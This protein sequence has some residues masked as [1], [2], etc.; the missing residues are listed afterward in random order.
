VGILGEPAFDP[1]TTA[2]EVAEAAGTSLEALREAAD[3]GEGIS[4]MCEGATAVVGQLH[5]AGQ[6]DA[7]LGLGGSGNT[8]IATAAMRSLPVGVPKVMVSTMASGDTEPY[9][10]ARDIAM[11]YSVADVEGLNQLS[12]QVIANAALATVGM[13]GA[14]VRVRRRN[15]ILLVS[16]LVGG[17]ILTP[18]VVSAVFQT[19]S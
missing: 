9:V 16:S 13:V 17:A 18:L 4:A 5:E 6:L 11:L 19:V 7:V 3:R 15:L 12:R 8:S 1:D 10:G 2:S 14:T